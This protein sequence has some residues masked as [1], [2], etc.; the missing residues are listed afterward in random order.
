VD[1]GV[2]SFVTVPSIMML[3]H[4]DGFVVILG[5]FKTILFALNLCIIILLTEFLILRLSFRR[6]FQS[7]WLKYEHLIFL[8]YII[9]P[10]L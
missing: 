5:I 3:G 6:R 4:L 10:L 8:E 1:L 7:L 2:L 9:R